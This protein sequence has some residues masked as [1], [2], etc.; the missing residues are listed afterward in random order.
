MTCH[1]KT[2]RLWP[3]NGSASLQ[4]K[5][6]KI[7]AIDQRLVNFF[8]KEPDDKYLRLHRPRCLH[9][10][11]SVLLLPHKSSP[12]RYG[13][14]GLGF[15]PIKLCLVKQATAGT[16]SLTPATGFLNWE[17]SKHQVKPQMAKTRTSAEGRRELPQ[18]ASG[19]QSRNGQPTP[20]FHPVS[21]N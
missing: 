4:G 8:C 13:N 5:R 20:C 7:E 10:D 17:S 9:Y 3:G 1:H 15:V 11:Y 14:D 2:K 12:R 21:H 6:N 16:C 18:G 19:I